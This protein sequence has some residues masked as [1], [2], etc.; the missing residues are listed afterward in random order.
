MELMVP[1]LCSQSG[2]TN[3]SPGQFHSSTLSEDWCRTVSALSAL[4]TPFP[5]AF[6]HCVL[7]GVSFI[8]RNSPST[9]PPTLAHSTPLNT[10]LPT[11][12]LADADFHNLHEIN[13]CTSAP[14]TVLHVH[15]FSYSPCLFFPKKFLFFFDK[16][17]LEGGEKRVVAGVWQILES[18]LVFLHFLGMV[19][20][21]SL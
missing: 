9:P 11:Y 7:V 18:G 21:R 6:V 5:L 17:N 12:Y 3:M 13:K 15:R 16:R 14:L 1:T 10:S 4:P 19:E 8:S 20:S 2:M